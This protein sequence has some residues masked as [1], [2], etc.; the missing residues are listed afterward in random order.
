MSDWY[1]IKAAIE[2]G[3]TAEVSILSEI[4]AAGV[5]ARDFLAQVA[6]LKAPKLK[7][8]INSPGG[9]VV[10][11]AAILNGLR[12]TGKSIEV[13]IL[14]IAASAASYIAMVGRKIVMPANTFMFIHN[15]INEVH[16][17]AEEMREMAGTLDKF[18]D[19][20][21]TE[22]AKRFK[23]S[24]SKLRELLAAET[25]LTAA[26]CLQYGLCDEVIDAFNPS[27]GFDTTRLP[28]NVQ[29]IFAPARHQALM[30]DTVAALA[31][32]AGL[33][34]YTAHFISDPRVVSVE[35]ATA[36]VHAAREISALAKHAGMPGRAEYLIHTRASVNDA[37][38]VLITAL[39]EAD[40]LTQVRTARRSSS[41][42]PEVSNS[43]D[44]SS[45]S[46][47]AEIRAMKAK[48]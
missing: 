25:W 20:L 1:T 21:A 4:G 34:A 9:S 28:Q 7:L 38:S 40:E 11:A 39:A 10:D 15:P 37:R 29:T 22:Y 24:D 12:A 42:A 3:D 23:G 14:G 2:G 8:S 6:T 43:A 17:N 48:A 18:G 44:W 47:W 19:V 36:V 35:S 41:I 32:D 30:A 46:L 45:T 33:Q 16:G 5:R 26:E 13:H 31:L 27:A